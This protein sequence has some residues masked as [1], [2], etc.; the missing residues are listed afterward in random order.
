MSF[1][2]SEIF[3]VGSVVAILD[4]HWCAQFEH[5]GIASTDPDLIIDELRRQAGFDAEHHR[6]GA[7]HVVD[8]DEQI[9]DIFHTAAIAEFAEI[10]NRA[11]EISEQ[12]AKLFDLGRPARGVDDKI[13]CLA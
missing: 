9:G 2:H 13:F 8:R 6:L 12:R 3:I 4:H 11:G 5:A 7:R 10:V 1:C